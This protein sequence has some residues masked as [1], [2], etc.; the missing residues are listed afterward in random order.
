MLTWDFVDVI[1]VHHQLIDY[2]REAVLDHLGEPDPIGGKALNAELRLPKEAIP[3]VGGWCPRV[4]SQ[5]TLLQ[6]RLATPRPVMAI[7]SLP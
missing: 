4:S 1:K 2:I 5:P 7:P 3:P 6:T